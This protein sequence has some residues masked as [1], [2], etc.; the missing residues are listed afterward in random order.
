MSLPSSG[1]DSNVPSTRHRVL[2][3]GREHDG[4]RRCALGKWGALS[5]R[6]RLDATS[7][8]GG[9]PRHLGGLM[10]KL[11]LLLT[12]FLI[13]ASLMA[14]DD[15]RNRRPSYRDP[16]RYTD[17]NMFELTPFLGYRYG[18]TI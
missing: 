2:R 8:S 12:L 11:T 13:P 6:A 10:R 5:A 9:K 4:L 15:W 14:Q 7:I 18:G 1:P 17:Q 16:Y 3:G